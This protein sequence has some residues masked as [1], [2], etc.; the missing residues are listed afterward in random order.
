MR[1]W[2]ITVNRRPPT[3]P[4]N[5]RRFP[6]EPCNIPAHLRRSPPVRRQWGRRDRPLLHSSLHQD[7][8]FHHALFTQHQQ[9]LS[10]DESRPYSHTS[11][12]PRMLQPAAH[13]PQQ[14]PIMVELHE[15]LAGSLS[16]CTLP[17]EDA[18]GASPDFIHGYHG[19]DPRF[20]NPRRPAYPRVQHSAAPSMLGN[21]EQTAVSALL[22][23]SSSR[24]FEREGLE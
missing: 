9:Q 17:V 4:F 16:D 15:Q 19:D 18:S 1:P 3:A 22:S 2:E 11:V 5:Q 14:N 20:P 7:E 21:V 12:P 8:N 13:P 24:E 10:L 23:S 6:G